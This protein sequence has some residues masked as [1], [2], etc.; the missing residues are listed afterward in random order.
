MCNVNN[1]YRNPLCSLLRSEKHRELTSE[2]DKLVLIKNIF[3]RPVNVDLASR[4]SKAN[5]I[6]PSKLWLSTMLVMFLS[7]CTSTDTRVNLDKSYLE[8]QSNSARSLDSPVAPGN[9][10]TSVS[11]GSGF[12][13]LKPPKRDN[14][15]DAK[16]KQQLTQQFSDSKMVKLAA[17]ELPLND[18]LHYVMGELLGVSYIVGE[19]V[20]G[21]T[22]TLT[23]NL[24]ESVSQRKLFSLAEGLMN[25]RGYVIRF[26]DG[27]YYINQESNRLGQGQI[28][29]GYGNKVTDVPETNNVIWQMAPFDYGFN[30][31]LG[32]T[33]GQL[34]KVD[35]SS[36]SSQN[37]M[38]LRGKRTEIIK[39]LEF[40]KLV[41]RPGLGPRQVA[42]YKAVFVA[43]ELLIV[44]LTELLAQEGIS[45][46]KAGRGTALSIVSLPSRGAIALFANTRDVLERAEYWV[47]E[48]DRPEEGDVQQYFIYQPEFSRATDLGKSLEPL[49]SGSSAGSEATSSTSASAQNSQIKQPA[50]NLSVSAG[51]AAVDMVVDKRANSLI[52]RTTGDE[53]RR[54]LPLIKRLDVMPQQVMLEVMIAEVTLT[55]EFRSGVEFALKSG[56]YAL[57][58]KGAFGLDK[59]G[60]LSYILTGSRGS[61][62]VNMFEGNSLVNVLSRPSIV[63]RDGVQASISVGTDIPIIG[64]TTSNPLDTNTGQTTKIEYRKTG[65]ELSVTPTINAQGVV[66]MVVKQK[67]SNQVEAGSTVV[68]SPSIFERSISTEVV[69]ESGQTVI[70]GG[71]RSENSNNSDS[72]A[73]LLGDVP[74]LG[75]LFRVDKRGATK[76]ELVVMITPKIIESP[77]QWTSIKANL[78]KELRYLKLGD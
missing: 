3:N 44:K 56:D 39:A 48:I 25:E 8:E 65:V 57:N 60:G 1:N 51:N 59:V 50:G 72:Q 54:L 78:A 70:M 38:V 61:V 62:N 58:S 30:G 67:N 4:L 64:E 35:V 47:E 10:E 55:D 17:D 5:S 74:V 71:L 16:P 31:T 2:L 69:A 66:I 42:M 11:E 18:F 63:V 29:F 7:A 46:S 24:Q 26:N 76:T 13:Y 49:L 20:K 9:K 41:D 52:F 33:M 19:T 37:M 68:S 75:E 21:D 77:Q 22:N 14:L 27:I 36:D 6:K 40:M 45:V 34:A 73:P 53:Y 12:S 43:P 28:V 32:L 23:L 15:F